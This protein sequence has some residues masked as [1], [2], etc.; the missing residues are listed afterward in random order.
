MTVMK[1][2]RR[3]TSK[4][5]ARYGFEGDSLFYALI[6]GC[7]GILM[8]VLIHRKLSRMKGSST[9][10]L[11]QNYFDLM[12]D[13]RSDRTPKVSTNSQTHDSVRTSK[14]EAECRR[15]LESIFGVPFP[16]ARPA[17]LRNPVTGH[18]LEIDCY[19]PA[20][21]LGV[22]YNGQQHY[23]YS[24]FFHRNSEAST[25]QKYRD[26]LKRRLCSENGVSLIEVPYTVKIEHIEPYLYNALVKIK[27]I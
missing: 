17:F 13:L 5:A 25:N 1:E 22:E 21:K 6:V 7:F 26:E 10:Y 19:N 18:C 14:G 4:K 16:K 11:K 12:S 27:Y 20:L 2:H 23:S 9:S 15:C 24:P 8:V 3:Y